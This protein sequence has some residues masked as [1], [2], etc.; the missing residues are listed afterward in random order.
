MIL[1]KEIINEINNTLYDSHN[2]NDEYKL[3]FN[4]GLKTA[5]EIIN[6]NI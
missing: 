6:S 1:Y 5:I 2:I 4:D 3:G